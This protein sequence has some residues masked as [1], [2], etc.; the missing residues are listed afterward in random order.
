MQF[1][2]R[3]FFVLAS[4]VCFFGCKNRKA[5]NCSTA[6]PKTF[7]PVN[8]TL[9]S[10]SKTEPDTQK[11]VLVP[12]GSFLMGN[13]KNTVE[14]SEDEQPT[15][16]KTV[17]RFFMD[18]TEVTI[19]EFAQFVRETNYKTMAEK[20]GSSLVFH[21]A[22]K[23]DIGENKLPWWKEV[24]GVS[25][26]KPFAE[27]QQNNQ[28]QENFPAVH[29][30][31]YDAAN[32][33]AWKGKRLPTETEWEY[34]AVKGNRATQP[35]NIF[36]GQFPEKNTKAD[37][38]EFMAP[39]KSFEPNTIGLYDLQGNVWEWCSDF[40]HAKYY[41]FLSEDSLHELPDSP[42]KSYDPEEPFAEKK[43]IRGGSF[44]CNSSYCSGYRP[45]ARMKAPPSQ[46]YIHVGFR[47]VVGI[48]P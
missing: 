14:R 1:S 24:K 16:R 26:Q 10:Y 43:V 36:Q 13:E 23:K 11:M 15:I 27:E 31:W 41:T 2:A 19:G 37:G 30:S 8:G 3:L 28:V 33:C 12:S 39:V 38:F 48:A 44:L 18:S 42:P 9:L 40:Y 34:A 47:C 46:T 29:V 22:K 7:S 17:P 20:S 25:W 45:T 6:L 5:E 32:Y 35:M 21:Y 4:F